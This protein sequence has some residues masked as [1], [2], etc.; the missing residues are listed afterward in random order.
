MA[1]FESCIYRAITLQPGESFT[2]PPGAEIVSA[3][4][5]NSLTSTCTIPDNLEELECYI[6]VLMGAVDSFN[7]NLRAVWETNGSI[8][9]NAFIQSITLGGITY[10]L[11]PDISGDDRG[12]FDVGTLAARI[13][14]STALSSLMFD[15]GTSNT[16]DYPRGGVATLCFKTIPSVAAETYLTLTT[17]LL[18]VGSP[19]PQTTVRVYAQKLSDYEGVGGT[20]SCSSSI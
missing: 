18:N 3:T 14:S 2:L 7:A 1:S 11:D 12:K 8:G 4:D 5:A 19:A 10:D 6:F 16:Y 17:F 9:P 15:L 20:C 13:T